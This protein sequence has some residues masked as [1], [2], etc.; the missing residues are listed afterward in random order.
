M[1]ISTMR[2]AVASGGA[3]NSGPNARA[4]H[5]HAPSSARPSRTCPPVT[6]H[7]R[8]MARVSGRSEVM[9]AL[10]MAPA[11]RSGRMRLVHSPGSPSKR[12]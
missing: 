12:A 7:W 1:A 6:I 3:K 9:P 4:P 10:L 11:S 5:S 2:R 8:G